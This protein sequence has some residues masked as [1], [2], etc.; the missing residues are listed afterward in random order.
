MLFFASPN[1]LPKLFQKWFIAVL[2]LWLT[3]SA[4]TA[5]TWYVAPN[6]VGTNPGT[7]GAP[8]AT[9]MEAQAAASFGDT[10]Y[11]RGGLYHLD[12]SHLTITNSPWAV[13]N[14]ITNNGVSYLGYPGELPVFDFSAVAPY[15][16]RT[17]A[18]QVSASNC[19]F[20][21]FD[22]VGV[23]VVIT[24]A[25]TQSEC[26]RVNG[27]SHNR[28]EQLRMHDGHGIGFYLTEGASNLVL[29]CDAYNNT[30]V[31]SFSHG[32]IDG[33]GF[34]AGHTYS[35]GNV[36]RGCRAWNNSD[37]AYDLIHCYAPVVIENC[38]AM[39]SGFFTNGAA[40]GGNAN[41]FKSGGFG[42]GSSA[43]TPPNPVP[44]HVTR[45]CL[46]VGNG[47][48]GFYANFHPDGLDFI[49]NTAVDNQW[50]YHM[51]CNTNN[52]SRTYDTPGINHYLRNNLGM[53][54]SGTNRVT[55][56]DT[57]FS[58]VD[59]NYFSLP[60]TVNTNDF[61]SLDKSLLTAPRQADGSLPYVAFAQL[62][63]GSDLRDAGTNV[64]S[65]YVGA[66][67]DL[68]AFEY[69]SNLPTL[70]IDSSGT[71]VILTGSNGPA[72]GM[73][74]LFATTDPAASMAE[75]ARVATNTFDLSGACVI[76]NAKSASISQHFFRI[77]LP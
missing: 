50:D 29:N 52:V 61:M 22:V 75:W 9:L 36:I 12:S 76:T 65:G 58:D 72:G 69:G 60:V 21:R 71:N 16:Y 32:N 37:D 62:V 26:F 42:V 15:G 5:D 67:P 13:V 51:R 57:N 46:A 39:Y 77:G 54:Y 56:L 43:K 18:F 59:F 66:A 14:F 74:Y 33:F 38:W 70:A 1:P 20:K 7:I 53:L 48:A 41:G 31:N 6:G 2:F 11:L 55:W 19:V 34:H 40:T 8:F 24:N 45:Y 27:G 49:G 35:T 17:T 44:R 28:F 3:G 23:P 10:V 73:N 4:V 63:S 68:G 64:G 30:G 47:F 25:G